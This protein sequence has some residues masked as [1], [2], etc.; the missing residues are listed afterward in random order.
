MAPVLP[1]DAPR[2]LYVA[3]TLK[4][5]ATLGPGLRG[6]IWVAGCARR[7][8]GCIAGPILSRDAG[9]PIGAVALAEDVLS[10]PEIDGVTFSGGEPFEQAAAL[11]D[12]CDVL[13]R[14]RDISL[15]SYTGYSLEELVATRDP[16]CQRLLQHLDILVDGAFIEARR[17]DL[18]WRGSDNQ[19]IHLLTS[20]HAYLAD[21][22]EAPSVGVE[23]HVRGDGTMFWA[24]IPDRDFEVF[25]A[26]GLRDRGIDV[27]RI[28]GV[29]T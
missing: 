11:A 2:E 3:H 17:G 13:R 4:S 15:M 24:G 8:P 21:T 23:L 6:V 26:K 28:P 29:W 19:R 18:L 7:C 22:V 14:E 1:Q 27:R 10:W 9:S 25:L 16:G 5:C 12:V 20:R